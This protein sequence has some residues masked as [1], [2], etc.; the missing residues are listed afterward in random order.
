MH[1]FTCKKIKGNKIEV[2]KTRLGGGG[3]HDLD[4][5]MSITE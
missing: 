3:G 5:K 4:F 2:E 1:R